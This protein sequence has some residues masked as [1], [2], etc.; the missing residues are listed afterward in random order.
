MIVKDQY[1]GDNFVAMVVLQSMGPVMVFMDP[2]DE[3]ASREKLEEAASRGLFVTVEEMFMVETM[4]NE[5]NSLVKRA[6]DLEDL[7]TAGVG[8][9][10]LNMSYCTVLATELNKVGDAFVKSVMGIV[11]KKHAARKGVALPDDGVVVPSDDV[12]ESAVKLGAQVVEEIK[13]GRHGLK[14]VKK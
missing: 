1:V 12:A 8:A 7:D 5:N 2:D 13:K 11:R 10:R 6:K 4:F 9:R 14:V 3:F